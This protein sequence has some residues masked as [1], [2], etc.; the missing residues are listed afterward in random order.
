MEKKEMMLRLI[1]DGKI[2]GKMWFVSIGFIRT[3]K[4]L[5]YDSFLDTIKSITDESIIFAV[6]IEVGGIAW[7]PSLIGH[8]SF[9][10]GIK[11]EDGT[12]YF[13]GDTFAHRGG[14]LTL[15]YGIA[16]TFES[17]VIIGWY[18]ESDNGTITSAQPEDFKTWKRIGSIHEEN[19]CEK[20]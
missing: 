3:H 12:W 2:V 9:E 20:N 11:Q 8:D 5:F 17:Y 13:E 7:S 6:T 14:K 1:K 15:K 4:E 10:R 19:E 16:T 18:F